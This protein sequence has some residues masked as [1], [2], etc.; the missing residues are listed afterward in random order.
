MV[1][2]LPTIALILDELCLACW[3]V[4]DS[5][6]C[7]VASVVKS[8]SDAIGKQIIRRS[9]NESIRKGKQ[10]V[11]RSLALKL[12]MILARYLPVTKTPKIHYQ[13]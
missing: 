1:A 7:D 9:V 3:I 12:T 10:K 2:K 5:G 4:F 13:N 6:F 8:L 11:R